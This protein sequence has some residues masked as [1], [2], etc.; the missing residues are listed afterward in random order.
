MFFKDTN[1]DGG[2]GGGTGQVHVIPPISTGKAS[3]Y[4][5]ENIIS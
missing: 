5:Y 1:P 4:M 2:G 3:L